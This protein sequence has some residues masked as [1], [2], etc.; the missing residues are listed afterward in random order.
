M[1]NNYN[2]NDGY[3]KQNDQYQEQSN[4]RKG[5]NHEFQSITDY[6]KDDEGMEH[7]HL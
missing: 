2:N 1:E 5:H 7:S 4:K 6:E 3:Y